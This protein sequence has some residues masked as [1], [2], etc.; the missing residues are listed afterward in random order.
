VHAF[1]RVVVPREYV[2]ET[3]DAL[4]LAGEEGLEAL[5]LWL[6][7]FRGP[8]AVVTTVWQPEQESGRA[9]EGL[10]LHVGGRELARL[11]EDLYRTSQTLLAQVHSHPLLAYHSEIDA[12]RP[13][14]TEEGSFSIVVPFLGLLSLSDLTGCAV[15]QI[16]DGTFVRLAPS[17]ADR[18]FALGA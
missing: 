12:A 1:R 5:V 17:Q 7:R 9:R 15:Y 4:Q 16:H 2:L 3:L 6:A 14:V 10:H 18:L 8:D 13:I 11:N